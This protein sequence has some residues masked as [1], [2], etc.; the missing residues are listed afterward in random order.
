LQLSLVNMSGPDLTVEELGTHDGLIWV[1]HF[2]EDN[3]Q[4]ISSGYDCKIKIWDVAAKRCVREIPNN[5]LK[6]IW[7]ILYQDKKFYTTGNDGMA[8]CFD[9][10]TGQ[11][12]LAWRVSR[13]FVWNLIPLWSHNLLLASSQDSVVH[14]LDYRVGKNVGRMKAEEEQL[15]HLKHH[16]VAWPNLVVAGDSCGALHFW[17]VR[18]I[19]TNSLSYQLPKIRSIYLNSYNIRDVIFDGTKLVVGSKNHKMRL[20]DMQELM[21]G[22]TNDPWEQ[23]VKWTIDDVDGSCLEMDDRKLLLGTHGGEL[24]RYD[25]GEKVGFWE[26]F[27]RNS[28]NGDGCIMM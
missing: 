16:P 15:T 14:F 12:I 24:R 2:L 8:R 11:E 23:Y 18:E 26:S 27:M 3:N 25:F 10:E 28:G 21:A 1:G 22:A 13:S 6:G 19:S 9:F 4:V 17:D 5:H 20:M 7:E